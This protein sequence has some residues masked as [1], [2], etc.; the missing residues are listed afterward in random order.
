[1]RSGPAISFPFEII[2][3]MLA[4]SGYAGPYYWRF[5]VLT[6]DT[7]KCSHFFE[8]PARNSD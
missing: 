1:M 4:E 3:L 8:R 7:G 6:K 5:E 2:P